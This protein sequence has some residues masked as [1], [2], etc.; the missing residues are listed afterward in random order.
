MT[1][2]LSVTV[3]TKLVRSGL[4]PIWVRGGVQGQHRYLFRADY[5]SRW[6]ETI[7]GAAPTVRGGP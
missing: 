1:L 3:L 2:G 6:I 7:I 4:S 5:L